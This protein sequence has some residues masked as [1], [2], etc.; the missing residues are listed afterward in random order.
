MDEQSMPFFEIPK[1]MQ[2]SNNT[3]KWIKLRIIVEDEEKGVC[4][5]SED[6]ESS[7]EKIMVCLG[8]I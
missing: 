4:V 8:N 5:I 1:Q 2:R 3:R 6:D 7:E